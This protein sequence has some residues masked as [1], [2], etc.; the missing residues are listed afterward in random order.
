M[1]RVCG[2]FV[3]QNTKRSTNWA[4][5]SFKQWK[6]HRNSTATELCPEKLLE[7][8][9]AELLNYWLARSVVE[10]RREDGENYP[11]S[12][13]NNILAGLYRYSKSCIPMGST[14]PNFMNRRDRF[15]E[16]TGALQVISREL[17]EQGV[18]AIVKHAAVVSPDEEDGLGRQ[19]CSEI[20]RLWLFKKQCFCMW[21]KCVA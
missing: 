4:L 1:D 6:E 11:P 21:E 9:N 14:C 10:I 12:S 13:L 8:P 16:L 20:I 18:G 17:R 7:Q 15:R 2:G 5:R 19:M 3:L